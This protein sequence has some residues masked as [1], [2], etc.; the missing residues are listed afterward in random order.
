M[1]NLVTSISIDEVFGFAGFN[2]KKLFDIHW[3]GQY[4]FSDI[5]LN[6]IAEKVVSEK[7]SMTILAF[8]R[9]RNP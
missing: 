9:K 1:Y 2:I 6:P 8:S 5:P 3:N 7:Y 4:I